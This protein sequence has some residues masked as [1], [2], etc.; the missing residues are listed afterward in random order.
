MPLALPR[1][2][3]TLLASLLA[4]L[5][6]AA[7]AHATPGPGRGHFNVA[8]T[9]SPQLERQLASPHAVAKPPIAGTALG[10]DV[11]SLQHAGGPINWT[12]VAA[13]R[14]H[15]VFIK[16]TE[17]SYYAN[18]YY[19]SDVAGAEAA[20][21]IVAAY[22]FANPSY[23]SGTLQADFALDHA[24]AVG[25]GNDGD[26]LPLIADLEYDPYAAEDH[27]NKCY[28]LTP[29]QMVA[30]IGAFTSEVYRRTGQHA[31]I[32]TTSDWWDE[33][34]GSSTAFSADPMWVADY[35]G[36]GSGTEPTLPAGWST[37]AFWQYTSSETVPG[38]SGNTDV[39]MLNPDALAVAQPA[40]Q[41]Y[42]AGATVSVPV[43]SV[44]ASDKQKLTY[45]ATGLPAGL[46]IDPS[47]GLIT[48][49]LP[50]TPG[51]STATVTVAGTG[52]SPVTDTFTWNVHGTVTLTT[53]PAQSGLPGSPQLLTIDASDS[54]P[55][56]TLTFTATGLPPGLSISPCG[57]ISGWLGKP[58]TY[59]PVVTA[60]DSSGAQL[61][62]VSFSWVVGQPHAGPAGQLAAAGGGCLATAASKGK[63]TIEVVSPCRQVASQRWT[64]SPDGALSK[65]GDCLAVSGAKGLQVALR[66]CAGTVFQDWQ[67]SFTGGIVNAS[68]GTCLAVNTK[69]S[70]AGLQSCTGGTAQQWTLPSGPLTSAIPGYCASAWHAAA[71]PAGPVSLRTCGSSTATNW[72]AE[73]DGTLRSGGE[74]LAL[75]YPA[76]AGALVTMAPCTGAPGQQW[77]PLPDGL[78]SGQLLNPRTGLC[79]AD[80]G[81][82][83]GAAQ[84]SL[85]DC[86]VT[87]P[88]TSWQVS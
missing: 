38:I 3:I 6:P 44:N 46:A 87:D 40:T 47:S 11:S 20:G 13:A 7:A 32:Y 80:E 70:L 30:W 74:C 21:L 55:G 81:D 56:C 72:T 31:V 5:V 68:T 2:T 48:G 83:P 64:F 43:R 36:S 27:T 23:S 34:T 28:G 52:L 41:S 9:H 14:Y 15:Y 51:T 24:G 39:S 35:P 59:E 57:V 18:P 29:Q 84:L 1:R 50:A 71:L 4:V 77:Q 42:Q 73:P 69:S 33:C 53:P 79:L 17:G 82:Q 60:S 54:L 22:H 12:E 8:N 63:T 76:V 78:S 67:P 49:T 45:S 86:T 10:I 26:S 75:T 85:G 88:G 58:G 16:A 66:P 37:W 19:A 62:S 25:L 61:G 65:G